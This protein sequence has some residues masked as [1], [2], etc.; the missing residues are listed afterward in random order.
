MTSK[1]WIYEQ[2]TGRV[3]FDDGSKTNLVDADSYAGHGE[4]LNNPSLE[5]VQGVGPIP[6]GEWKIHGQKDHLTNDK[7][8]LKMAMELTPVGHN[9]HGRSGFFWH[10]DAVA[11]AGQ[12]LASH[13]CI[14]SSR[15]VRDKVAKSGVTKLIVR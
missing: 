11:T 15:S 10:G 14:I 13:G 4:G 6:R 3:F 8:N 9:A 7:R 12:H 5:S 1:T 2:K